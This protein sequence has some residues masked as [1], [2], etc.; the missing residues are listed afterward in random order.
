MKLLV[1][2]DHEYNRE[3]LSFILED[4][5][6]D[7]VYAENG[8]EACEQAR[9][10]SDINLILMDVTMPVMDGIEATRII[11]E[12]YG[13][14]L[15]PI[16]FV[17]ALDDSEVLAKCLDAGG[18]D[19]VPKPINESILLAKIKAHA[20]TQEIYRNLEKANERL[21]YHKKVMDR[22]HL[23]VERIFER[24][25]NRVKTDCLNVKKYTSPM[26]MFNGDIILEAP[27]PTG[28]IYNLV[29]DFTG[30]GLA[31]SIGTLPVT[32]IFYRL[33][34]QQVNIGL[35]AKEINKSLVDLL[36]GNMFFCCAITYLDSKGKTLSLWAGGMN[37]VLRVLNNAEREI[38]KVPS[39]HM[40][41]GILKEEE[42]DETPLSIEVTQGE[43]IYIY[44]DGINEATNEK[45]E[46]FGLERI[47]AIVRQDKDNC[48]Q[49]L[50]DE[51]HDYQS[52]D[53]QSDDISL[54]EI[55][56]DKPVHVD[57]KT[58]E[59]IDILERDNSSEA[60]AWNFSMKLQGEELRINSIVDQLMVFVGG[61]QGV[62]LHR[63]KIF[64]IVSELYSNSLEHGVLGLKS[65]LKDTADGFSQYYKLR[66]ENLEKV[67]KEDFIDLEFCFCKSDSN[68]IIL[69]I[70]DSG[71]GFD[72]E[73]TMKR[74]AENEDSHGRGLPLLY[75]LCSSLEYSSQGRTVT[76]EY[77][78]KL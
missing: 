23:I 56:I 28:G 29:G 14:K 54:I 20:R 47:E 61:I 40:P 11:K 46:E 73:H 12:E 55:T 33:S 52:G 3:L 39:E 67:G 68:S 58:Q 35:F 13:E 2:D 21:Q 50:I 77:S 59:K 65:S 62:E 5:G 42:F 48:M 60:F 45:D 70:T 37:D 53:G 74:L 10:D 19:F 16:I 27:S 57:K 15:V 75:D 17:T 1:V 76:A 38:I 8:E 18:D 78:L 7:V 63:E 51:V 32:E 64:T 9:N 22:E 4:E 36:P 41:L 72:F 26:S 30:H 66:K 31:A 34:E 25:G 6:Y 71:K 43:R 69:K 49:I 44:S 24:G